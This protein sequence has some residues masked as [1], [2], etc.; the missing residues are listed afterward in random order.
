M[1]SLLFGQFRVRVWQMLD[2]LAAVCNLDGSC[3]YC[4]HG[5]EK[6]DDMQ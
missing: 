6:G 5:V 3:Q 4:D 2:N 1:I